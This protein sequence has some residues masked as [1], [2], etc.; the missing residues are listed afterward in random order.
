MLHTPIYKIYGRDGKHPVDIVK[1]QRDVGNKIFKVC[2]CPGRQKN[3][4]SA[5]SR[6]DPFPY[7]DDLDTKFY[8]TQPVP[9]KY[10]LSSIWCLEPGV[11]IG[12]IVSTCI[13]PDRDSPQHVDIL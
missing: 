6:R 3:V 2:G 7:V 4:G 12:E 13:S 5:E 8:T 10:L 9:G 1:V 11:W